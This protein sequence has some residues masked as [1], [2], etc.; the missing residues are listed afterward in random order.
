MD[1]N[2]RDPS[3]T[4]DHLLDDNTD[5]SAVANLVIE[6]SSFAKQLGLPTGIIYDGGPSA[7]SDM[8]WI[9][10]ATEHIGEI[11]ASDFQ[12][13]TVNF[14]SW[15]AYPIYSLPETTPYTFTN[16]IEQYLQQHPN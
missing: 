11:E 5:P 1:V 12:P 3:L 4:T 7:T 14:Q 6:V 2:W 10:Q 13:D 8:Q 9:Q 16:L 15:Y